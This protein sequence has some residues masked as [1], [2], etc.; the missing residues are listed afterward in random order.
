M[1]M[2][3][4]DVEKTN[5]LLA[6]ANALMETSDAAERAVRPICASAHEIFILSI[7]NFLREEALGLR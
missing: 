3:N 4:G 7:I 5:E 6:A 2:K 1:K